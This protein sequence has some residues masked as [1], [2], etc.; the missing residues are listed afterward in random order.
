MRCKIIHTKLIDSTEIEEYIELIKELLTILQ[1]QDKMAFTDIMKNMTLT[2]VKDLSSSITKGILLEYY[3]LINDK[4]GY[5][6][7]NKHSKEYLQKINI[8][9]SKEGYIICKRWL[10]LEE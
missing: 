3:T 4:Q 9:I 5:N 8:G 6:N 1:K 7:I 2:K 10:V